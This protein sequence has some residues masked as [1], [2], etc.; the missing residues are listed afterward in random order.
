MTSFN[1]FRVFKWV[2]QPGT[3]RRVRLVGLS[4]DSWCLPPFPQSLVPFFFALFRSPSTVLSFLPGFPVHD[5]DKEGFLPCIAEQLKDPPV[6]C[7][8]E[9]EE[10]Q[11]QQGGFCAFPVKRCPLC[12]ISWSLTWKWS[13]NGRESPFWRS[14]STI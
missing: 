5:S 1:L 6:P 3:M 13:V 4:S 12:T 9:Q 2:F 10:A 7:R 8:A 14:M 11:P